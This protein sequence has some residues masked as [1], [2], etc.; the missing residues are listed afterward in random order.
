MRGATFCHQFGGNSVG[1][2]M[3]YRT[4][5]VD[6]PA[7]RAAIDHAIFQTSLVKKQKYTRK[8][9][10]AASRKTQIRAA[11][12]REGK[13]PRSGHIPMFFALL[14]TR[15]NVSRN[16]TVADLSERLR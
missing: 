5:R 11:T 1:I 3:I 14:T 13:L 15:V 2:T 8:L 12:F 16:L 7:I 9:H 10:P 6:A 4:F